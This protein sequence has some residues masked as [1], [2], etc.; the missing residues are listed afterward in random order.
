[1]SYVRDCSI[2]RTMQL[3][4]ADMASLASSIWAVDVS[5]LLGGDSRWYGRASWDQKSVTSDIPQYGV[6]PK[7]S[8]SRAICCRSSCWP[9]RNSTSYHMRK[10]S[11][12]LHG[13]P[14]NGCDHRALSLYLRLGMYYRDL[15]DESINRKI[16]LHDS[17]PSKWSIPA[18]SSF[19]RDSSHISNARTSG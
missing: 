11:V 9:I 7:L 15:L 16:P 12:G 17:P 1:L 5:F 8:L 19:H 3:N 2:C 13:C 14:R 18:C 6:L 4:S 10:F